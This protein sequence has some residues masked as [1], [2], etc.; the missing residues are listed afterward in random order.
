MILI[1]GI[2]FVVATILTVLYFL[3]KDKC[4]E[5]EDCDTTHFCSEEKCVEKCTKAVCDKTKQTCADTFK[6]EDCPTGFDWSTDGC[7]E[8]P[9]ETPIVVEVPEETLPVVEVPEDTPPVVE[10]P[11]DTPPVVE[12]PED[13]PA[14]ADFSAMS[15]TTKS[16]GANF[17]A[18]ARILTRK[19]GAKKEKEEVPVVVKEPRST[20]SRCGKTYGNTYC[21]PGQYCSSSSWCGTSNLHKRKND[22]SPFNG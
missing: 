4:S 7:L 19:Q 12:V 10:V 17:A 6:C 2:L 13:T 1:F 8:V 9:D 15:D 16:A 18:A 21:P 20:N 22:N 5:D 14:R 11:E 3:N